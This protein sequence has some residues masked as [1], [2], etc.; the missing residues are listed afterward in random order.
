MSPTRSIALSPANRSAINGVLA[1][2]RW[3]QFRDDP[4]VQLI[5]FQVAS[6]QTYYFPTVRVDYNMS[7]NI[8][9][10]FAWN[11]TQFNQPGATA[12]WFPGAAFANSEGAN[13]WKAYTAA[14]GFDWT[15]Q[16]RR[17]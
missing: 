12:P 13:K 9:L 3:R 5:T 8:R 17:W 16:V 6:P 14:F 7:Q 1:R 2:Q 11:M 10:S 15:I 4:N